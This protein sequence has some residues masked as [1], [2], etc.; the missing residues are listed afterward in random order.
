[1][2]LAAKAAPEDSWLRVLGAGVHIRGGEMRAS[3]CARECARAH[4]CTCVCAGVLMQEGSVRLARAQGC[5][6]LRAWQRVPLSCLCAAH[7]PRLCVRVC[8][9]C[10]RWPLPLGVVVHPMSD[11]AKGDQVP[12]VDLGTAGIIRCRKCR[13]Y[14][15]PH[16][17]WVDGGRRCVAGLA[18]GVHARAC[19]SSHPKSRGG[20]SRG[21]RCAP[22]ACGLGS[23]CS[24]WCRR[25]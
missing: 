20:G 10:R 22:H 7:T 2:W 14:M 18:G 3:A 5:V 16:M 25:M 8:M 11:D 17:A 12:I 19:S 23:R 13:T 1:M 6:G 21:G 4:T 9:R 24:T 15:N